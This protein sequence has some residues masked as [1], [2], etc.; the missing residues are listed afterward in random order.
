MSKWFGYKAHLE[1]DR[2][3]LA[4]LNMI[5]IIFLKLLGSAH[6]K[7]YYHVLLEMQHRGNDRGALG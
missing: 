6:Y 1:R 2:G 5:N 4:I 3:L 7:Q